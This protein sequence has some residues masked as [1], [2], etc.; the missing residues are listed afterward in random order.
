MYIKRVIQTLMVELKEKLPPGLEV[1]HIT[2]NK[3]QSIYDFIKEVGTVKYEPLDISKE[4]IV[5]GEKVL[6]NGEIKPLESVGDDIIVNHIK[7]SY[8]PKAY[9]KKIDQALDD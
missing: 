4:K 3:V 7:H 1:P 8:N 5:I 2:H 6:E 9:S